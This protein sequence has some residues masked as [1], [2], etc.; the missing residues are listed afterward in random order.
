MNLVKRVGSVFAEVK[1]EPVKI[2]LK[3]DARPY[4]ITTARQIPIPLL[5]KA[6]KE[7][8]RMKDNGV[9]EEVTLT[10]LTEWVSP[11]VP[12]LKPSGDVHI[13]VVLKKLNQSVERMLSYSHC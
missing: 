2:K 9:I 10:E 12:V 3:S 13:C 5:G 8:K 11:I 4:S 7:L 6:E 1:C